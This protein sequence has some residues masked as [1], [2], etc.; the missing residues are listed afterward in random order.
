[1]SLAVRET[2]KFTNAVK[3]VPIGLEIAELPQLFRSFGPFALNGT[4]RILDERGQ[5]GGREIHPE[6]HSAP[7]QPGSYAKGLSVPIEFFKIML[8]LIVRDH[9]SPG[10][11]CEPVSNSSLTGMSEGRIPDV[12]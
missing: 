11:I 8:L 5:N 4:A 1:M 2:G 7:L 12:M 6:I 3:S 9:S 10:G